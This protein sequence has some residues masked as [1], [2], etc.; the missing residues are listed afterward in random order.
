MFESIADV[1]ELSSSHLSFIFYIEEPT[2]FIEFNS[3]SS[4]A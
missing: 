4:E 2:V 1:F 3:S